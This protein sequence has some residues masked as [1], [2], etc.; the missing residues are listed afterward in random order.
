[1]I[2]SNPKTPLPSSAPL[3]TTTHCS[4]MMKY[5]SRAVHCAIHQWLYGAVWWPQHLYHQRSV[6]SADGT[7]GSTVWCHMILY[8]YGRTRHVRLYLSHAYQ[9]WSFCWSLISTIIV[10]ITAMSSLPILTCTFYHLAP[11]WLQTSNS[12]ASRELLTVL[13]AAGPP[14]LA[15]INLVCI[16]D[17]YF[18]TILLASNILVVSHL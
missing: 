12:R 2:F 1:M 7:V 14:V 8:L 17:I 9:C 3:R 11:T 5:T 4:G 16:T 6:L 15:I 10:D 18:L 13:Q